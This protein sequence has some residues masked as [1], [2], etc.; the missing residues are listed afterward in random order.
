MNKEPKFTGYQLDKTPYYLERF[1]N[2]SLVHFNKEDM[3]WLIEQLESGYDGAF[4]HD[5]CKA[6]WEYYTYNLPYM[7]PV[8]WIY[9]LEYDK[10]SIYFYLHQKKVI[11]KTINYL[12]NDLIKEGE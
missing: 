3:S 11:R 9:N 7:Y 12:I 1:E 6:V 8:A 10:E 2:K 5:L 4:Y